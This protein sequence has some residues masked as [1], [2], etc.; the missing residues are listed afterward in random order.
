MREAEVKHWKEDEK[1]Y[2]TQAISQFQ[3]PPTG[4]PAAACPLTRRGDPSPAHEKLGLHL[5]RTEQAR[6]R[7]A[8]D[9]ALPIELV[10]P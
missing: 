5:L 8:G 4:M 1:Q 9:Q 2:P 10:R 3:A 7:Q 6:G